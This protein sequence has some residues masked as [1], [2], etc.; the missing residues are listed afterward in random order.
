[1]FLEDIDTYFTKDRVALHPNCP[2]T[3]SGLL[4]GLDG[5]A[6]A[7]GQI[8][9]LTTNFIDKL[10]SAL[11]RTGRVDAKYEFPKVNGE[12]ARLLYLQFYP[13][14]EAHA[15]SF[16]ETVS[17]VLIER[18]LCMADLQQYFIANRK[19][20]S[21]IASND[22]QIKKLIT[23][24]RLQII[25]EQLKEQEEKQKK[26][27][28]EKA[29]GGDGPRDGL[30]GL[31]GSLSSSHE[32]KEDSSLGSDRRNPFLA[33]LGFAVLAGVALIFGGNRK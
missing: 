17:S 20:P 15:A 2:L 7:D 1:L 21:T 22:A 19:S 28:T 16:K 30:F 31:R 29:V 3:F 9:I 10:D 12:L 6:A 13:G 5:V 4:N 8:F 11:I 33:F 23:G 32:G 26:E 25:T 27:L 24:E 18:E 14:E